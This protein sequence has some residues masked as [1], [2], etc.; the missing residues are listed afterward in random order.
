M[1]QRGIERG[2]AQGIEQGKKSI[3]IELVSNGIITI[4]QAAQKAGVD[5][6]TFRK[7]MES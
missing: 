2:I 4:E 6:D 1:E 5:V 3:L 7:N